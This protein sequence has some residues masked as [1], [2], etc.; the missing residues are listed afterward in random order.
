LKGEACYLLFLVIS[1]IA[2][3][4]D[5]WTGK[6]GKVEKMEELRKIRII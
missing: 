1:N 6:V 5:S 4:N 3:S 2:F